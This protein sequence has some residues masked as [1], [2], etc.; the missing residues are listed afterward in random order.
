MC[1][2]P[3]WKDIRK[4]PDCQCCKKDSKKGKYSFTSGK[5]NKTTARMYGFITWVVFFFRGFSV[6]YT[7]IHVIGM[8]CFHRYKTNISICL[9][10]CTKRQYPRCVFRGFVLGCINLFFFFPLTV[11][12]FRLS[13]RNSFQKHKTDLISSCSAR[14]PFANGWTTPPLP[15][16]CSGPFVVQISHTGAT[17]FQN[18]CKPK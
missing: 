9:Y 3:E 10:T 7:H 6:Q 14:V 8:S 5:A 16:L 12:E 15:G 1:V 4:K 11:Y 13:S 2:P 17:A 18:P